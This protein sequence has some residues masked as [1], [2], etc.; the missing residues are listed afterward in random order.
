MTTATH[1]RYGS[2]HPVPITELF[3]LVGTYLQTLTP[4]RTNA[5]APVATHENRKLGA[6][7]S[8]RQP[9]RRKAQTRSLAPRLVVPGLAPR[10]LGRRQIINRL[11]S[12]PDILK[13]H[14]GG[15]GPFFHFLVVEVQ[16]SLDGIGNA[17]GKG[18][19]TRH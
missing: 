4:I 8:C 19:G 6:G 14:T 9:L 7:L 1:V 2:F 11:P 15:G 10:L 18:M 13:P 3:P 12:P 17:V 16:I 5:L